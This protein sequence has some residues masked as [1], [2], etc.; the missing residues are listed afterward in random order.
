MTDGSYYEGTFNNG[1]MEGHGFRYYAQSG[2]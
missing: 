1:E 2:E